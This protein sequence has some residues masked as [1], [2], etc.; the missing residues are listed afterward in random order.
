MPPG[1]RRKNYGPEDIA[2]AVQ[3]VKSDGVSIRTASEMFGVPKSTILDRVNNGHGDQIGRPTELTAE[4]E[5]LIIEHVQLMATW[6]FPFTG[7]DL[8][9]FVKA[10]LDKKGTKTRFSNNLPTHRWVA[11]FLGRHPQFCMRTANPIKRARAA[12]SREDV[13][14]FFSH[15]IKAVEGVPPENLLNYDESA[16]SDDPGTKKCVYKKG[17]KHC[18]KVKGLLLMYQGTVPYLYILV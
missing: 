14:A 4:E 3:A 13:Q 2:L 10:Y 5:N 9:Y 12:V 17:T 6:G 8:S 15:Y 11:K 18:E 1:K 7:Q 16:F